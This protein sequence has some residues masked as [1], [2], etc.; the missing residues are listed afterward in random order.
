MD[1]VMATKYA[2]LLGLFPMGT[3]GETMDAQKT[4]LYSRHKCGSDSRCLTK[5][6]EDRLQQLDKI[7]AGIDKPL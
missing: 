7:Y 4:W 6:Y 3:R 2:F 1:V 5:S